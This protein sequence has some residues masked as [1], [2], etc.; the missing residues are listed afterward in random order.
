M[1]IVISLFIMAALA[2]PCR[3]WPA[4]FDCGKAATRVEKTICSNTDL[5]RADERLAQV[6]GECL[7][8][9]LNRPK[10]V[11]D[12]KNW[13]QVRNRGNDVAS[14]RDMYRDRIRE[15]EQETPLIIPRPADYGCEGFLERNRIS[16]I[17]DCAVSESGAIGAIAGRTYHYALFCLVPDYATEKKCAAASYYNDRGLAVFYQDKGNR[18]Q[19]LYMER[20]DDDI[21]TNIYAKPELVRNSFGQFLYIPIRVDGT[22]NFNASEYYLWNDE[23]RE[24]TLLDATSWLK[25]LQKRL[26]PGLSIWKGVWPD[27]ATMTAEAGL[28]HQDDGNCCPTGGIAEITLSLKNNRFMLKSFKIRK[29][30]E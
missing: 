16:D 20:G 11:E 21:G 17:A 29:V 15:L 25:D 6:Y 24:W 13:L 18:Q 8:K 10:V 2:I 26:P 19:M 23:R 22:G 28:Y 4:S 5:S 30:D 3:V 1:R 27:I 14:L 9:A 7:K 12:Q